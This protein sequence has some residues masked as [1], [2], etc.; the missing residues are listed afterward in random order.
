MK[1]SSKT[2]DADLR[3][4]QK[5]IEKNGKDTD[6]HRLEHNRS[7]CQLEVYNLNQLASAYP[8]AT[9]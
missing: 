5:H 9:G 1:S 4:G 2:K 6:T 3:R 8:V 7:L